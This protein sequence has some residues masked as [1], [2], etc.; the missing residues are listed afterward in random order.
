MSISGRSDGDPACA[1]S[2]LIMRTCGLTVRAPVFGTGDCRFDPG[3]VFVNFFPIWRL[4]TL[5]FDSTFD[6][7]EKF[8][9]L[10]EIVWLRFQ[11]A[12][13]SLAMFLYNYSALLNS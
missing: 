7:Q 12:T 1:S 11:K 13:C 2:F 9:L 8:A 5:A 4:K 6:S 10:R 3:Q